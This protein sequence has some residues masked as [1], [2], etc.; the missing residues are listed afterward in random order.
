M[1]PAESRN[2][3]LLLSSDAF[4]EPLWKSLFRQ[5][6]DFFFSQEAAATLKLESKPEPVKEIWGFYS[7]WKMGALGATGTYVPDRGN[8]RGATYL[9]GHHVV[10]RSFEAQGNRHLGEP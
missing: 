5:L 9:I 8:H 3:N 4:Q 6:D 2:S 7:N 10:G 1:L